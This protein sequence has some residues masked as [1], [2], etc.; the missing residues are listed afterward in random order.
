MK[1]NINDTEYLFSFRGFGPQYTYETITGEPFQYGSTRNAHILI[2]STLMSCNLD[3]FKMSIEEFT[4]WLYDH[5][6]EEQE[7]MQE[8]L[9]ESAR[10]AALS[11]PKKK[12]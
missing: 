7:M 12:E 8:I 5:P 1:I 6:T 11:R 9:D 10:R 4:E 3:T 2:F